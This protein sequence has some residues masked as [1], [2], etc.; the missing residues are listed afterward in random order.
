MSRISAKR[1][2]TISLNFMQ[3]LDGHFEGVLWRKQSRSTGN[4]FIGCRSSSKCALV[5]NE[6][7]GNM[8]ALV[9]YGSDD[10]SASEDK[11][12]K[13]PA[14]NLSGLLG[15]FSDDS[16]A[17]E[18]PKE[19]KSPT[20]LLH[21]SHPSKELKVT[22][23]CG[24]S[25]MNLPA[26]FLSTSDGD[27]IIYWNV[28]YLQHPVKGGTLSLGDEAP[29]AEDLMANLQ[30]LASNQTSSKDCWADHLRAQHEF[31]NPHFFGSVVEHFGLKQA[32]GSIIDSRT[33]QDYERQLFPTTKAT[34][35][36][37]DSAES[38]GT[39]AT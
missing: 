24:Q 17:G 31:H 2:G 13:P 25:P 9:G 32:L 29:T 11:P 4:P 34:R 3:R 14:G 30:R 12:L 28:D 37:P 18:D 21:P 36:D 26:P 16:E 23:P 1:H 6:R 15:D 7:S 35:S 5:R 33:V 20:T 19:P 38:S 8:D 27:P 22:S 39:A 10:S